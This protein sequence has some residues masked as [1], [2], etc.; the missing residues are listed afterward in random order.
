M[1]EIFQKNRYSHMEMGEIYFWTATINKWKLLL[2]TPLFKKIIVES[3]EYLSNKGNIEV[4]AF[5]IMP[6]HVHFIWRPIRA[7]GK[8]SPQGSFL[9][10]TAHRFKKELLAMKHPLLSLDEFKVNSNRKRFEF[11]QRDPMA[12]HLFSRKVM[13]QK[14]DYIHANPVSKNWTLAKTPEQYFW[15]SA[16]FYECGVNEFSFLK[17]IREE[18]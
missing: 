12:T 5:V 17:D 4:F 6:N 15:S 11:W 10:F 7:N 13:C 2:L 18:L 16:N 9:K 14:L 3:L 1:K 8:E